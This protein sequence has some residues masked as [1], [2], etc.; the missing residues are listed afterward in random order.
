MQ[1]HPLEWRSSTIY[2]V[3]QR[4]HHGHGGVTGQ[5]VLCHVVIGDV[6]A[7]HH[8]EVE[9]DLDGAMFLSMALLLNYP[10]LW[11]S[12]PLSLNKTR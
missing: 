6:A 1:S 2:S 12:T 8:D 9:G 3:D 11:G 10:R 4:R 7:S 5:L